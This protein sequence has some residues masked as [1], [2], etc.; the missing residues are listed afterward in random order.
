MP[1]TGPE[2]P[3]VEEIVG[4]EVEE[5]GRYG[6][7]IAIA[8]VL[9]TLIGA[10]VAF[11]QASALRT[12]DQADARAEKDGALALNAAAVNRGKA[13][14]QIN[15]FNLLTQQV[16]QA[17]NATLFQTYGT[18]SRANQLAAA[19]WNAIASQTESDTAAIAATQEIPS[20]CAPTIEKKCSATGASY[21]PEQDP[22]F[23]NRYMQQAQWS[24]YRLTALRDGANQQADD[25]EA[26]FVA[27]AAALTMLAVAVFL[28]GYS[29]TPQGQARRILY[30][31]VA[32]AFVLVAGIWAL[33]Q[34]ATPVSE[35][36]D[37]AATAFAN[38]QVA[39]GDLNDQAAISAY[40]RALALRPRFV[41][42]YIHRAAVEFD[43]GIPHL[44]AAPNSLP[45]T[46]NAATVPSREALDRAT[47]D[48]EHAHD[49]GST[50][51]T[52]FANLAGALTYRGLL[53]NRD[54]DLAQSHAYAEQAVEK[55][56]DQKNVASLLAGTY[57]VLAEDDLAQGNR[58]AD[59]EYRA[60]EAQLRN[61]GVNPEFTVAAALTDLSLIETQRPAL[62]TRADSLK[63][64]IVAQGETYYT[65]K[66]QPYHTT[67]GGFSPS[68]GYA[69]RAV[70]L[71]GLKAEPDPGHALYV[72]GHPHGFDPIRDLLS[73][74]WEYQDPLHGEWAVLP[75]ISGPV[76]KGGLIS[77]SPGY[78]SDN[79]S[80][81][82]GT[83]PATCMPPGHYR[84]QL[85]VNGHLAGTAIAPSDWPALHA[86]RF[87]EVDGAVCV[88]EGWHAFPN[89]G[90]GA[91]GYAAPDNSG[92]A[93]ILSIPR[94]AAAAFAGNQ[95][96][97]AGVMTATVNGF[98]SGSGSILPGLHTV[99]KTHTTAFFM[100]SGNGQQ[101]DYAYNN[102][103]VY[104]GVGTAP[105]GQIYIGMAWG[106]SNN[107][108]YDLF[109][110]L[111]P[112]S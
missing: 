4:E 94:A 43:A 17:G 82:S 97:L 20:I 74:Q 21:S 101:Q 26:K 67:P 92:G 73:A 11:A 84:V 22:Q 53:E 107:L 5:R 110:S 75:Q 30:S 85:F 29:L 1:E 55:L 28:F 18:S 38:A 50:S 60:A 2:I 80:Y 16:R 106:H 37:S 25:A 58:G 87:S 62:T 77:L 32:V 89:L 66:G 86:V 105:N 27:Y 112:L 39:A 23:P 33:Y 36:P 108:A 78:A 7:L 31:R 56:K 111:S 98:S 40:N 99:G 10:L 59:E 46:A 12:H 44:G 9:T 52:L 3:R 61:R 64:Q 91:D 34:V 8:V 95:P 57:F 90:A 81:V 47:E 96:A 13:E 42:A 19:R 49:E 63:A 93:F 45:T 100:S 54:S 88:P 103:Y 6:R 24:A 102:G 65:P 14:T 35:P 51:G 76:S 79:P 69:D 72:I 41:D 71:S 68:T 15:R 109:L 83:S 48:L 70:Q 104:S